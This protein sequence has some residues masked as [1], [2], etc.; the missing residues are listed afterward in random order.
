MT[1]KT[2]IDFI[3]LSVTFGSA[4]VFVGYED[5][6]RARGLPLG[7][8][9]A[10]ASLLK[11]VSLLMLIVSLGIS[12]YVYRWWSPFI[13]LVLGF[14]FGFLSLLLLKQRMQVIAALGSVIGGLLCLTYVL[15]V[16][17]T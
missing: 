11:I 15:L 3:I 2:I 9:F 12:F 10:G 7:E 4:F 5:Y 8:R 14:T 16:N 1:V 13:V 17:N 6:A